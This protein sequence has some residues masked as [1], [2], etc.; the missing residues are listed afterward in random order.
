MDRS[1]VIDLIGRTDGVRD[2]TGVWRYQETRRRVFCDVRSIGGREFFAAK[3]QGIRAD[4]RFTLFA[5]DYRGEETVEHA[6]IRYAVYR[7]YQDRRGDTMELYTE[8]KGGV[9]GGHEGDPD[10]G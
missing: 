6:G 8:R 3:E 10:P 9:Y 4:L 7:T 1:D 2:E 5:P